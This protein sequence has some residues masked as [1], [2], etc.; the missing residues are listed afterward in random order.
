MEIPNKEILSRKGTLVGLL[1]T[2]RGELF[3][4]FGPSIIGEES[5]K[6]IR[7]VDFVFIVLII[8]VEQTVNPAIRSDWNLW[9]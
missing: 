8:W 5:L 3:G 4:A 7:V 1:V 6:L 9:M 2:F